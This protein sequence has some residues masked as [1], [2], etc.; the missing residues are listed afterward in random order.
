MIDI[1]KDRIANIIILE[2]TGIRIKILVNILEIENKEEIVREEI[3]T[4]REDL[5][6]S[7]EEIE[8]E[9]E[10]M[11]EEIIVISKGQIDEVT[12]QRWFIVLKSTDK[13]MSKCHKKC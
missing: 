3:E 10:I 1:I 12:N 2:E 9:I 4:S 8:I 11:K 13:S 7:R 5:E 6:T